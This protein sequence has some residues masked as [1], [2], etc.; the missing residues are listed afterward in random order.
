MPF[1]DGRSLAGGV[2]AAPLVVGVTVYV[3]FASSL[4]EKF[5]APSALPVA[6][7]AP[8][9]VAV[10]PAAPVG[11]GSGNGVSGRRKINCIHPVVARTEAARWKE[12][13]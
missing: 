12:T 1:I 3:P 6:V 9:R 10:S 13:T 4:K 11:T 8:L 2:N 5:P 7:E